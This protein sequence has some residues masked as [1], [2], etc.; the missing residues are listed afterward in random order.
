MTPSPAPPVLPAAAGTTATTPEDDGG[1]ARRR[2]GLSPSRA[3]DF[4]QCPLLFRFRTIDRLPEPPSAAAVRGTLVH[5]VLEN[6]YDAPAGTRTPA[7]A[8][9]LLPQEWERLVADRPEVVEVLED[10]ADVEAWFAGA[11]AL[12][13]TYFTLEDP[14][15]LEPAERELAVA[16]ELDDGPELRGIVDR[17]DVAP[18]GA[19]RIVDYKTGRSP[20]EGFESGALFQMRFYALV[21]S[22]LRDRPPAMLQLVYLGDG[23]VLRHRPDPAELAT[24]ERRIRAIWAGILAAAESGRWLPRQSALCGWCAHQALCPA[25]GGE[26]PAVPEGAVELT[27]GVRPASPGGR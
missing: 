6:L 14:N 25:F 10:P 23:V 5:A 7:T 16:T 2:P 19:I 3:N 21:V 4:L 11:G 24:T 8:R 13:D 17:L 1:R 27:L 12:L 18:D 26:P 9:A 15:R 20:R 22:R